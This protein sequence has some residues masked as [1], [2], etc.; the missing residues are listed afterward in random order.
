[1]TLT[2]LQKYTFAQV[3]R[4]S[5]WWFAIAPLYYMERGL[6]MEQVFIMISIFSLVTV[7][8]EY[9]TGIIADAF[10]HKKSIII[11][12]SFSV[13]IALLKAVPAGFYFYTILFV[14]SAISFAM[15][16]GSDTAILH[17]ISKNFK[18]DLA[19][20]NAINLVWNVVTVIIG[21]AAYKIHISLPYILSAVTMLISVFFIASIKIDDKKN[22]KTGNIYKTATAG[23]KN[24]KKHRMLKVALL[25]SGVFVAFFYA[26]KWLV[27]TLLEVHNIDATV[28]GTI[29]SVSILMLA[30]STKLSGTKYDIPLNYAIPFLLLG[31]LLL[32]FSSSVITIT[33][34]VMMIYFFRGFFTTNMT[35][36]INKYSTDDI[37][38]SM[39]SL[40]SL[41]GR[42]CMAIYTFIGGKIIGLWSFSWL[43]IFTFIILSI[44]SIIFA[45]VFLFERR[46]MKNIKNY[47]AI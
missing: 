8:A 29:L 10:S 2:N 19:H 14:L 45:V 11:G 35:V 47:K 4:H 18:K 21:A 32:G 5:T 30:L 7:L 26:I 37:R 23:L 44:A 15:K 38:A 9:P 43:T 12:S 39:L 31:V 17:K 41:V 20:I 27:P 34:A 13:V 24:L 36:L 40:Q 33:A 42:L 22:K 6:T 25:L 3:I 16:S 46:K 1:M 28:M